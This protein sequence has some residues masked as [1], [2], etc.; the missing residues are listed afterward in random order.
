MYSTVFASFPTETVLDCVQD[1][2][3]D[4]SDPIEVP[5]SNISPMEEE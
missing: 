5:D 2:I 3:M 1:I 4:A